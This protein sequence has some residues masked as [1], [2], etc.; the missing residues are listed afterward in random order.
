[1][2]KSILDIFRSIMIHIHRT[3]DLFLSKWTYL[4]WNRTHLGRVWLI[5]ATRFCWNLVV[6]R[7]MIYKFWEWNWHVVLK[8]GSFFFENSSVFAPHQSLTVY[9]KIRLILAE[10]LQQNCCPFSSKIPILMLI[11]GQSRVDFY[12][13]RKILWSSSN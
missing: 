13:N 1:M 11:F 2:I 10:G 3:Q 7:L 8:S 6:L 4:W 9:D 12:R 5:L